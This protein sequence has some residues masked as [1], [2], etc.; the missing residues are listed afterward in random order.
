MDLN[1][2]RRI[3]RVEATLQAQVWLGEDE[4]KEEA[5]TLEEVLQERDDFRVLTMPLQDRDPDDLYWEREHLKGIMRSLEDLS[6]QPSKM[7]E[8][9]PILQHRRIGGGD[10]IRQTVVFTRFY[11]TL[12]DIVQRLR[13]ASPRMRIGT[14]SGQGEQYLNPATLTMVG[15]D[16]DAIKHR[17][18]RG[19]IDV[20]VC[21]DAA[22]E[23]LNLQTADF[24]VNCRPSWDSSGEG[25]AL[26]R[27]IRSS[28]GKWMRSKQTTR[29]GRAFESPTSQRISRLPAR[30][31]SSTFTFRRWEKR[32]TPMPDLPAPFSCPVPTGAI[33]RTRQ[34]LRRRLVCIPK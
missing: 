1:D 12:T 21:T 33:S 19:E 15:T 4:S 2:Q 17:F 16:R 26:E 10:R 8:L 13:R 24:P 34:G 6:A 23:G 32:L 14:Y 30:A 29:T 9:L 20:L 28:G 27:G 22:A 5:S 3:E 11:D 31:F 18:L 7:T 25:S